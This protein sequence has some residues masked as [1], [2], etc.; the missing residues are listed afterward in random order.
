MNVFLKNIYLISISE[1]LK[2][3]GLFPPLLGSQVFYMSKH[4]CF[5]KPVT[6]QLKQEDDTQIK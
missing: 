2:T 6:L 5:I 1:S 4:L 3:P